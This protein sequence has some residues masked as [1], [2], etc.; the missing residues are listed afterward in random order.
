MIFPEQY[1]ILSPLPVVQT[2]SL[3]ALPI[4]CSNTAAT[5]AWPTANKAI[6]VP[7]RMTR[8]YLVTQMF[9]MNGGVA[10][11]T[12]D[13]GI[14]TEDFTKIVSNGAVNQAGTNSVQTYN[15]T[16]T[17]LGPGSYY[18]A[19]VISNTTGTTF[20]VA[21]WGQA[22]LLRLLGVLEQTSASPLPTLAAPV[23]ITSIYLPIFG[24]ASRS[25]V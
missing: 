23:G 25:I 3:N 13:I 14:Y 19:M 22:A 1:S 8:P 20:R 15:I 5:A 11:G 17:L 24:F 9:T 2:F 4:S 10:S 12:V 21:S 16:D 7:F 18:M 6:F